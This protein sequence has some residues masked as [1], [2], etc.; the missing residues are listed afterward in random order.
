[1]RIRRILATVDAVGGVWTYALELASA[2]ATV[3][4]ETIF[5]LMGP[6]PTPEQ[7]AEAA[8][9][10][11]LRLYESSYKLE[12]M[13]DPWGDVE[14]AGKWLLSLERELCPDIVHLNGYAHASLNWNAPVLVAGHSCVLSWWEA[15]HGSKAGAVWDTYRN[16]VESGLLAADA[17]VAPSRAMLSSLQ[18]L[19][20]PFND[21]VVIPN[22]RDPARFLSQ[23][24][25]PFLMMAGRLRDP[26]KNLATAARAAA[27]LAWPLYTAGEG[28]PVTGTEFLG[29][30]SEREVARWLGRASI[31]VLPARYEPFGL[32]V[33]EAA[34][35]GCALVL[36]DIPSLR[37]NWNGA[38][39]FVPPDHEKTLRACLHRLIESSEE[40][41]ALQRAA[42]TRARCLT[43][44][45]MA[46]AYLSCYRRLS[47]LETHSASRTGD[48][49]KLQGVA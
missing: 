11:W 1:M 45:K 40:R 41:E 27:G 7:R 31:Y 16:A 39:V 30:L 43:H 22:G 19:Y 20:G 12:W 5:A 9:I 44:R 26:G 21:A 17:I 37:E 32:S 35:S 46:A 29:R 34:L 4:I 23:Q 8:S 2:L 49:C 28:E 48:R 13:A 3:G 14:R 25:E 38:A 18:R 36:G 24:K 42:Q 47:R 10:P 33:L 15:V 6:P